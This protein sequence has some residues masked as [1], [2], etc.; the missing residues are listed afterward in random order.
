VRDERHGFIRAA[1]QQK[2]KIRRDQRGGSC[3]TARM[4][5]NRAPDAGYVGSSRRLV[6]RFRLGP[7]L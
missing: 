4:P 7:V 6:A 1:A 5:P 3:P 2:G